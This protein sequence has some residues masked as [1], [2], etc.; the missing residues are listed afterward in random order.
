MSEEN[1]SHTKFLPPSGGGFR[2][3]SAEVPRS[4]IH[5]QEEDAAAS[6]I[7]PCIQMRPKQAI[8]PLMLG[9]GLDGS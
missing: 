7:L 4:D 9:D 8:F 1:K 3:L 5:F 2:E 6:A